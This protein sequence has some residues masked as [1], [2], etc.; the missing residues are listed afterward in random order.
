MNTDIKAT[1]TINSTSNKLGGIEQKRLRGGG[2]LKL[3]EVICKVVTGQPDGQVKCAV[4]QQQGIRKCIPN[5]F[6]C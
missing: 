5:Q 6:M 4:L 3:K 1:E 2:N